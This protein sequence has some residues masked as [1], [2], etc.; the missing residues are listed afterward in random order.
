M[1]LER[2][3]NLFRLFLVV[4]FFL[5][6]GV[7]NINHAMVPIPQRED[8]LS[9]ILRSNEKDLVYSFFVANKLEGVGEI[10]LQVEKNKIRG[11]ATGIG[12]TEKCEIDFQSNFDGVL[13]NKSG[14]VKIDI[15]GTGNPSK[16]P[17]PVKIRYHGPLVGE[18]KE[19]K[20]NLSGK[21]YIKGKLAKYAGFSD[22]EDLRIEI[23]TTSIASVAS[24]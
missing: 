23:S 12:M 7:L 19:G 14:E 4:L 9:L 22:V 24:L 15:K 18:L 21:V 17:L 2:N 16:I 3:I 6:L 11:I 20:L 1:Y 5:V 10:R 8:K 13:D